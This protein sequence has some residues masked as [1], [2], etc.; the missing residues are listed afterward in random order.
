MTS[1]LGTVL[2]DRRFAT[3]VTARTISVFGT[4]LGPVALAFGI[5]GLPHSSPTRLSVVQAAYV[6]PLVAFVLFAGA[7]ADRRPRLRLVVTA[8]TVAG[9]AWTGFAVLVGLQHA[10]TLALVGLALVGGT[11]AALLGPTMSGVVPELAPGGHL[12]EANGVLRLGVNTARLLGLAVGGV[13]VASIGADWALGIDALTFFVSA[14][15]IATLGPGAP[16]EAG[17]TRLLADLRVGAREF[18]ARQWLWVI[19]AQFSFVVAVTQAS[20][21]VLG[22]IVAKQHLGGAPAWSLIVAAEALGSLLGAFVALRLRPRRPLL[23]ATL[24]SF[25][26]VAPMLLLGLPVPAVAVAVAGLAAGVGTDIFG[27]LWE[28][29]IQ[30]EIP[31]AMLSRVSAYDWLGSV[32]LAPLGIAVA[33]PIASAVGARPAELGCAGVSAL[34]CGLALLSPQVRRLQAP[35]QERKHPGPVGV[36][37]PEEA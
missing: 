5:L 1:A 2:R 4:G 28:T 6:V 12:Q 30:R 17:G 15:V 16:V 26:L 35:R 25:T 11:G 36:A 31:P 9:L 29:T 19:V 14:A 10:P 18:F 32:G 21:G 33:G 8:D 24:A 27:V 7:I 23:V 20:I 13:L 37:V 34:A 3:L 22:P